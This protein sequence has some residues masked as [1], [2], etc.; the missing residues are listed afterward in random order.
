MD[1]HPRNRRAIRRSVAKRWTADEDSRLR[2]LVADSGIGLTHDCT[3]THSVLTAA[4]TG[5]ELIN[6]VNI[7]AHLSG[8][9]NKDSHRRW[10]KIKDDFNR[11]MWSW[12]E[13]ERLRVAVERFGQRWA[14]VTEVVET[15][16]PDRA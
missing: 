16:N 6:W 15:R 10:I 11:G 14:L 7:S 5:E 9:T 8:R 4:N 13:D 2:A 1:Q 12:D 3:Q